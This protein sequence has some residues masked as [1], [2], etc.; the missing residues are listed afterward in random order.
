MPGCCLGVP[1]LL[2]V[3]VNF[4]VAQWGQVKLL[5]GRWALDWP[6]AAAAAATTAAG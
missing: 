4:P 6:A 3:A 5:V 1:L 2:Q